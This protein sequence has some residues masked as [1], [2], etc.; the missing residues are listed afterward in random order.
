LFNIGKKDEYGRQRR[1]EH[2]GRYLRASRTGGVALRAQTKAAG[3]TITG[4]TARGVRVSATPARNTQVAFQNG[5]FILRGRY[6]SGPLR[7]NL[8]KSGLSLSTRN[9]LGSF[10]LTNPLRSSAKVA[11]IQVRGKT[12][13]IM[14]GVYGLLVLLVSLVR[15]AIVASL[16]AFRFLVYVIGLLTRGAAAVPVLLRGWRRRRQAERLERGADAIEREHESLADWTLDAWIGALVLTVFARGRGETTAS[17]TP[18]LAEALERDARDRGLVA[19]AG[20]LPQTAAALDQW[21]GGAD[22]ED[23]LAMVVLVARKLKARLPAETLVEM[24][25]EVDEL[26]LDDGP[27]TRLQDRMLEVFADAAGL[28]LEPEEE[29]SASEPR[30]DPSGSGEGAGVD[31]NTADFDALQAIPHIG[32]ERARA[33]MAM[34]PL[35]RIDQLTA[36]DGIGPKRLQDIRDY[37]VVLEGGRDGD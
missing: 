20:A 23:D 34:R 7:L 31:I 14:Q 22:A 19:A 8:S 10:N 26:V 13:A 30:S 18:R 9:A 11:G 25:Y 32:P 5:R 24:L 35:G 4:N 16:L 28:R 12:A 27:R 33:I 1:I 37:G 17:M 15:L 29:E 6:G 2:R 3:L 36:L 21:R